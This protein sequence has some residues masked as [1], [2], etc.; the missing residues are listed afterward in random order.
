MPWFTS[1]FKSIEL[2]GGIKIDFKNFDKITKEIEA[3]GLT[4]SKPGM[5][6]IKAREYGFLEYAKTDIGISLMAL[7]MELEKSLRNLGLTVWV[8]VARKPIRQIVNALRYTGKLTSEEESLIMDMIW[9]LNHA[10]HG[11]E[12]DERIAKWIIEVAPKILYSME[13]KAEK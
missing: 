8:D 3:A 5:K 1:L 7:R 6:T 10:A 11:I 2:P 13:L 12:F 4:V 9:T